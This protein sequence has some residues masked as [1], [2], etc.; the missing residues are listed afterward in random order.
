[1]G[2]P[3]RGPLIVYGGNLRRF[4]LQRNVDVSG[5]S[6]TGIVAHGVQFPDGVCIIRWVGETPSTVIWNSILDA[7]KIHGHG[8][9][10]TIEWIDPPVLNLHWGKE[11]A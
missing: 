3:L 7:E 2:G 6:G 10:T 4:Y 1:M 5:I 9:N 8:G 11:A